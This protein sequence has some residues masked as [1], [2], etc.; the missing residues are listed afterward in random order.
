M[1]TK[2]NNKG[3]IDI[4]LA[5]EKQQ[6]RI[7]G[8]DNRI[9]EIDTADITVLK[10]LQDIYPRLNDLGIKGFEINDDS[11]TLTEEALNAVTTALDAIDKEMRELID[12]IFDSKISDICV[13]NGAMYNM[14]NGE[15]MF[16]RILDA[17]FKLYADEIQ[18]EFG[19]MSD[20][21]KQRTGKY[22]GNK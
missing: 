3:I 20:R 22:T 15:F 10:R 21:M 11:D 1:G 14:K 7:D 4:S 9:I 6:I 18:K 12:Y 13:P 17:L 5:S 2:K 16:E 8:D 19:L